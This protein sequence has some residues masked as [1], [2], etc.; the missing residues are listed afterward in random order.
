MLGRKKWGNAMA[1]I[2]GRRALMLTL[3]VTPIV[4]GH[5]GAQQ[6]NAPGVTDTEIKI[7]QSM[8]YSGPASAYGQLGRVEAAYFGW[9]NQHGGINGRKITLISVDDGYSPPKAVEQV[10]KLVEQDEVAA[11]FNVLGTPINMAIRKYLNAKK[12][13][14]LF[15]AAGSPNFADP[16]HFPWTIGWQPTLTTEAK[17]YAAHLLATAPESK[18]A[19][20]YQNDDFG[21]GLLDGLKVGLG[22]KA[23]AMIIAAASY[24]ATDPTIDSQVVTLQAS[25]AD[26]LFLFTYSKQGAQAIRKAADIGWKPVRYIHLGAASVAATFKPAGFDKSTGVMT[27]GFI[28]DASDPQWAD[29]PDQKTW[30]AWMNENMP[31]ADLSDS[32]NVAGYSFAQT[33]EQV[34]RQCGDDLSRENI[35]RQATSLHDFRLPMLLPGSLI[36][37]SPTDY[38][39]ITFMQLQRFNGTSWDFL[40]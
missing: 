6:R 5:A 34:L 30:R 40:P 7:G 17:F 19:V 4:A 38:R 9:L 22:D 29:D 27:A 13:P 24:E 32:V 15:V 23:E 26:T 18:V 25:G 1:G 11:I 39:V 35:M 37:T 31:G 21:K 10:R 2:F 36:N 12:V 20:L 33:L 16:E 8:P 14:Q 3:A 28:K